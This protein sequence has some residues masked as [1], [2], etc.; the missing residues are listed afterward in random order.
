MGKITDAEPSRFFKRIDAE[1]LEFVN[2]VVEK[3][4]FNR[5]GLT[6]DIL[7]I[8]EP[9]FVKRTKKRSILLNLPFNQRI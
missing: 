7:E 5:S 8:S 9:K 3:K 6:S 4:V 2:P 1:Y